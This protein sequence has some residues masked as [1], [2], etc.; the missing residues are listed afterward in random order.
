[1]I[2]VG[3]IIKSFRANINSLCA[4]GVISQVIFPDLFKYGYTL[5]GS[6]NK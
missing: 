5:L 3:V 4:L 6:E 2:F 1:M